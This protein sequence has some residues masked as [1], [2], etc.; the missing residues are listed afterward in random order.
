VT[1]IATRRRAARAA[2]SAIRGT[3]WG[4]ARGTRL[5]RRPQHHPRHLLGRRPRHPSGAPPAAPSAVRTV[6]LDMPGSVTA[7]AGTTTLVFAVTRGQTD[8]WVEPGTGALLGSAV[9]LLA[10]FWAVE[11]RAADPLVPPRA[12]TR[13]PVPVAAVT[14]ACLMA[15][16]G[17][18]ASSWRQFGRAR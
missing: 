4:A 12:L 16:V 13:G 17:S 2:R 15:V 18:Q 7:T 9:G 14:I 1:G 6:R 8:G 3:F 10:S 5:G 11:A